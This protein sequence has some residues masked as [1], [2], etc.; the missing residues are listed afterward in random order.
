MV[1]VVGRSGI[2]MDLPEQIAVG[3]LRNGSV[4]L[5]E[6]QPEVDAKPRR[7]RRREGGEADQD[8]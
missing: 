1:K 4:S 6:E 3:M 5:V 7:R 8:E 2:V